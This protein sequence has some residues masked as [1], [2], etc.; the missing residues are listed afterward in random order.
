M[1][2]GGGSERKRTTTRVYVYVLHCPVCV[3]AVS[4][5]ACIWHTSDVALFVFGKADISEILYI[6][7]YIY[8][9]VDF[10]FDATSDTICVSIHIHI[11]L[12]RKSLV[13]GFRVQAA[14]CPVWCMRLSKDGFEQL[15][16]FTR[17]G[18][19]NALGCW[20]YLYGYGR[21]SVLSCPVG[22]R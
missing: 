16:G 20:T 10:V 3:F 7:I 6:Y 9:S 13:S 17:P 22:A 18:G 8:N 21:F 2:W 12:F 11:T 15:S 19:A 1:G 4:V 14:S 5:C